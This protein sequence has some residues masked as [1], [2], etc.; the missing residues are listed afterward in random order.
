[1]KQACFLEEDLQ[2]QKAVYESIG[3]KRSW[4]LGSWKRV[5]VKPR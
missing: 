1:M 2:L 3:E 4:T 5:L